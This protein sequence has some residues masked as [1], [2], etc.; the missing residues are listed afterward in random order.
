VTQ[1]QP[2]KP[3][4]RRL[5]RLHKERDDY[6]RAIGRY[7]VQFSLLIAFMRTLVIVK[8]VGSDK[9]GVD[10]LR[11]ALGSATAQ[12][13]SDAF[14]AVCRTTAEPEF[15]KPE[16]DIEKCLREKQI[17]AEIRW[18]NAFAHGDWMV[19]EWVREWSENPQSAVPEAPRAE[20]FRVQHHKPRPFA[21]HELT[22]EEIDR[23]GERVEALQVIAWE[24]GSICMHTEAH[25]PALGRPVVRVQDAFE[26]AGSGD[27]KQVRFRD[28]Y[29]TPE[30]DTE[31]R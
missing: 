21:P 4:V 12:Q 16:Q 20:L 29:W 25:D 27:E 22:P 10:L 13:V 9:E 19:P 3:I 23:C 11:L 28:D 5:T 26:I 15:D 18:R 17:N 6:Y 8:A 7:F 1:D 2:S 31:S 30:Q 14:F 24:F